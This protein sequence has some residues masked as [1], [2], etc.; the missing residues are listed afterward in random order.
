[1]KPPAK[2]IF[3]LKILSFTFVNWKHSNQAFPY[4]DK[5]CVNLCTFR[6]FWTKPENETGFD[7]Y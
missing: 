6:K 2:N 7:G 5:I 4:L 1:M 3:L